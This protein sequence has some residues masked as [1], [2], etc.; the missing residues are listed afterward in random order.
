MLS[1]GI[2]VWKAY[3]RPRTLLDFISANRFNSGRIL[4]KLLES[5]AK[6]FQDQALVEAGWS[7]LSGDFLEEFCLDFAIISVSRL[8]S[9]SAT[10]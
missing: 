7:I 6:N 10:W 8:A 5:D 4:R 1:L 2:I 3:C 9:S